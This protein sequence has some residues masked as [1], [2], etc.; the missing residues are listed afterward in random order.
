MH[1]HIDAGAGDGA[2][3]WD[4]RRPVSPALIVLAVVSLLLIVFIAEN[5]HAVRVR[6]IVPR[7]TMPVWVAI[8]VC[9]ALG[10]VLDRLFLAWW[11]RRKS[12]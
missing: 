4:Q 8:L 5:G 10:V 12:A 11:R 9:V 6:L 7:V 3:G 2:A 1:E